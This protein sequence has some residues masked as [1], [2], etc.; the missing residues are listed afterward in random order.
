MVVV[1]V[2]VV[3]VVLLLLLR[4][5]DHQLLSIEGAGAVGDVGAC[6]GSKCS[7][8]FCGRSASRI[9]GEIVL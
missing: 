9:E 3:V 4:V 6:L 2:V 8:A 5:S 1:G 7:L